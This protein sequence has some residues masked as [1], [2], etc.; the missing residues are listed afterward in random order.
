METIKWVHCLECDSMDICY[1]IQSKGSK[2]KLWICSTCLM[3]KITDYKIALQEIKKAYKKE[4][5]DAKRRM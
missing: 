2:T 3:E 5:D 1:D 4:C